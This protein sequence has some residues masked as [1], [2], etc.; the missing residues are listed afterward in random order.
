MR[1]SILVILLIFVVPAVL[2]Y[3]LQKEKV[4]SLPSYATTNKPAI[5]KFYSPMCSECQELEKII[6]LGKINAVVI[7]YCSS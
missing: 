6:E 5:L 1:K 7:P 3:G 4:T 2:Y